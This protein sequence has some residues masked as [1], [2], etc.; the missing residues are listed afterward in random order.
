MWVWRYVYTATTRYEN[1][2]S[3]KKKNDAKNVNAATDRKERDIW[4][5]TLKTN[6]N[7]TNKNSP[8]CK[9]R[10][11]GQNENLFRKREQETRDAQIANGKKGRERERWR[12]RE[13]ERETERGRQEEREIKKRPAACEEERAPGFDSPDRHSQRAHSRHRQRDRETERQR[14]THTETEK[15]RK[16]DYFDRL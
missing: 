7:K 5:Q 13:R 14:D 15:E 9:R 8:E 12:E 3:G 16:R 6:R 2:A 10:K 11:E 1:T 4:H